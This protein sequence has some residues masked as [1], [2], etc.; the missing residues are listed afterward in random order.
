MFFVFSKTLDLLVTPLFWSLALMGAAA[1]ARLSP[2]ARRGLIAA[3]FII[4]LSFSLEPVANSLT[5]SVE[6]SA[7]STF[8]TYDAVVILGGLVEGR[9]Q[10]STH[11]IA[12]NDNVERLITGFELLRDGHAHAAILSGGPIDP[13]QNRL[14]EGQ[15][16]ADE[17]EKWG[18]AKER[19]IVEDTSRNTR[20]NAVETA[21]LVRQHGFHSLLLVTSAF[22]M[23][24]ALGCFN[25]AGLAPDTLAVD[26]RAFDSHTYSQSW[27]PRAGFLEQSS[28]A[29]REYLGRLVYRLRGYTTT[30]A[31]N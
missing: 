14:I 28:A 19:L 1:A 2:R 15:A 6:A 4:L 29:L 20:E 24:R 17:L 21:R 22:H 30:A 3:A 11:Q 27:L 31:S 5:H 16:L 26:F 12:Y 23:A 13:P 10:A 18:I 9:A 25:A 8:R 7:K